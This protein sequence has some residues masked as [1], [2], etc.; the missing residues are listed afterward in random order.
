MDENEDKS[1]KKFSFSD[2]FLFITLS[3]IF[4]LSYCKFAYNEK[5]YSS[6]L[7]LQLVQT[8]FIPNIK[9]HT[10][11]TSESLKFTELIASHNPYNFD[12]LIF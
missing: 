12:I 4:Y 8:Y 11:D 10:D 3:T 9:Q 7:N 2:L 6:K 5:K 1:I